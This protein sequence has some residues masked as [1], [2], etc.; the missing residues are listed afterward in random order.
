MKIITANIEIDFN[1]LEKLH[2]DAWKDSVEKGL[3]NAV[4]GSSGNVKVFYGEIK[5]YHEELLIGRPPALRKVR[6]NIESAKSKIHKDE[7]QKEGVKNRLTS[8]FNYN[9][10]VDSYL[11]KWGAYKL[12][13]LL[14]TRACAYCN[15]LFTF[16]LDKVDSART[17]N[18]TKD[19]KVKRKILK[20]I[21]SS[22]TRPELDHFYPKAK[23]PYLA[24]AIYNLV[25]SCHICNSN[26]KG[27]R[28]V[29]FDKL[30]NPFEDDFDEI[31][32]LKACLRNEADIQKMIDNGKLIGSV[33]DYFGTQ[34]FSGK[35][36]SFDIKF[37]RVNLQ[38]TV[39]NE[40]AEKHIDLYAL[41]ELYDMH[42][43]HAS[44]IIKNAIRHGEAS[45]KDIFSRHKGLFHSECEA[46]SAILSAE[47]DPNNINR[48]PLSKLA[49]DIARDF[50]I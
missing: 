13:Q 7:Y 3:E 27:S 30:I 17:F 39:N 4:K 18:K 42:K 24:L 34:L 5:K 26:L 16:T 50:G 1:A 22:K 47:G 21:T 37:D 25:P 14:D 49:I 29:D 41:E 9:A 46:K 8:I 11:P 6:N 44:R 10:F 23:F 20:N 32:R 2:L 28:N 36:E 38:D 45:A 43:D 31:I 40:K 19:N 35:L 15:R 33:K 48:F 12:V